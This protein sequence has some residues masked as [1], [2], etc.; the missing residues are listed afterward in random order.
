MRAQSVANRETA[1]AREGINHT[2]RSCGE[3]QIGYLNRVIGIQNMK[4][5][6]P[7]ALTLNEE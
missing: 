3:P 2:I 6:R 4:G 1:G 7:D 5:T